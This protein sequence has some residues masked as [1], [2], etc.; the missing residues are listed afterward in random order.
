MCLACWPM[1]SFR[2]IIASKPFMYKEVRLSAHHNPRRP[3]RDLLKEWMDT[4]IIPGGTD[5]QEFEQA[6]HIVN[7]FYTYLSANTLDG[8]VEPFRTTKFRTIPCIGVSARLLHR[9]DHPA[10]DAWEDVSVPDWGISKQIEELVR[11]G[12]AKFTSDNL[13]E[14]VAGSEER[15]VFCLTVASWSADGWWLTYL[16]QHG[17]EPSV[18]PREYQD[19]KY[20][21]AR[22][23]LP[24]PAERAG[25][26]T[27][28]IPRSP[29]FCDVDENGSRIRTL[30]SFEWM[31]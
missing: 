3:K 1:Q 23:V 29:Q 30:Q 19:R 14:F 15:S 16:I 7:N 28:A 26:Y 25:P 12:A 8:A 22:S 13:V 10:S 17:S 5:S 2:R 31:S 27:S 18:Q 6:L 11:S 9:P 21:G 4:Q 20:C 24:P